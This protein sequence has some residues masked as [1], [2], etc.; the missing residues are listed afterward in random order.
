MKKITKK[1]IGLLV[2]IVLCISL[3][4]ISTLA[5]SGDNGTDIN[6][7][8]IKKVSEP[9][10]K[11][12]YNYC[13]T[14]A[15]ENM[16][17]SEVSAIRSSHSYYDVG[18]LDGEQI[19]IA[20]NKYPDRVSARSDP[21]HFQILVDNTEDVTGQAAYDQQNGIVTLPNVYAGHEIAVIW[22]CPSDEITELSMRVTQDIN[23]K[24]EHTVTTPDFVCSSDTDQIC[25]PLTGVSGV[26][27]AQNGVDIPEKDYAIENGMLMINTSVLGGDISINAAG[28]FPATRGTDKSTITST[29]DEKQIY[30]GY[31]TKYYWADGNQAFCID[32]TVSG[33]ANGVYAISRYLDRNG[34]DSDKLLIKCAYYLFGGPGYDS[35]KHGLFGDDADS[36][37]AYA[38]SHVAASY[39]YC[40]ENAFKGLG[41]AFINHAKNMVAAIDSQSM[42]P[43]GFDAFLYNEGGYSGQPMLSWDYTPV[44]NIFL[45][46]TSSKPEMTQGNNCYSLAGAVYGVYDENDKKVGTVTTDADGKGRMDG[47]NAGSYYLVEEVAPKGF[48]LDKTRIPCA[49]VGGET[50]TIVVLDKPQNDPVGILLRKLDVN[51]NIAAAQGGA[52]LANAEFTVKYYKGYYDKSNDLNGLKPERTWVFKTN[53]NGYTDISPNYLIAG[54]PL[55]YHS[56]GDPTLPLG[57]ITIQETKSPVGYL[58]NNELFIRQITPEGIVESVTTYNEPIIKESVIRGDVRVE[59]WDNETNT[60]KPQGDATLTNTKLEIVNRSTASVIVNGRSY[61]PGTVVF[62]MTTDANGIAGTQG[63]LLPFGRYELRESKPPE[64]YQENGVLSRL[65]DIKENGAIINL[66]TS[67]TA[68]KNDVIRGGVYIEKWDNEIDENRP[69]G[70][71]TLE[72]AVFE[73]VNRSKSSVLVNGASYIPGKVVHT[74][75]TDVDGK[76]KTPNSLLPYGTYEVREISPP[77]EGYL[78][79]GVLSRTFQIRENG[80]MVNLNTSGTAIKNDPIRGDIK[81]VKIADGDAGRMAN[82]PF[83]ITSATTGESHIIITD[84][85][86][87]FDTSSSWNPHSQN[88]NR[89]TTDKDGIW[90]GDQD[91][92]NDDEGALP[93]DDYIIDELLCEANKDK[94]LLTFEIAVYR[95]STVLDLGTLTD[96]YIMVPEIFTT[97]L[98]SET[99]INDAHTSKTTTLRDTVYHSGLS[100][101]KLYTIQGILMDKKTGEPLLLDGKQIVSEYTFRAL[102]PSGNITVE[103]T[104]DST[105][106][107][108]KSIVVFESLMR[109]GKIVAEHKEIEDE[110]QTIR[111]V[112]PAIK[113]NATGQAGE[114]DLDIGSETTIIDTV[115]YKG[116]IPGETYMLK[117]TVMDKKT[118]EPVLI[119]GQQITSETSF[120]SE[121]EQGEVEVAFVFNNVSLKGKEVVIFEQLYFKGREVASHTD[122]NDKKQT[123]KCKEP[124]ISTNAMGMTGQK[125][126]LTAK[127][128]TLVDSV[129]FMDLVPGIEYHLK[130]KL[131]DKE[132]GQPIMVN[133]EEVIAET[134]FTPMF[135]TGKVQVIFTFNALGLKG[136]EIVIFESLLLGKTEV[137]RHADIDDKDQ[138]VKFVTAAM[139]PPKTGDDKNVIPLIII[140]AAAG[141]SMLAICIRKKKAEK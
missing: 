120:A 58:I 61:A 7:D 68:I 80:K 66:N 76:A 75:K 139:T 127:E 70:S 40:G 115:S 130:G 137:A 63:N 90:F 51:S 55:Y 81:G 54:D 136:K 107:D 43:S 28:A 117:G 2:A 44:G 41:S 112:E 46:K 118:G 4:P 33:T 84:R 140:A 100:V 57:T 5:G 116:L 62:A 129:L 53:V 49:V 15:T 85:N 18:V 126:L 88:T 31:Y 87:Q 133:D 14:G 73:I 92:L 91:T 22:N 16:G 128:V 82:I 27:V 109:D 12:T 119:A 48:A 35:V 67:G 50:I 71:G 30:Y 122:I 110:G 86:G 72:G 83:K 98:D 106:L 11:V 21:P 34:S 105:S 59:K 1:L 99:M 23:R 10:V 79:I 8:Q 37:T 77:L 13:D 113:T 93:Y 56:T 24:D 125:E 69:Q 38:L 78:A 135:K 17:D 141:V 3:A 95:D 42:P 45:E 121:K 39:V 26:S 96:D 9:L 36:D 123:V 60:N 6:I 47:L 97:A 32:P 124:R 52:S 64:G 111:F 25:I 132:T 114:K 74:I 134:R 108:G 29:R 94:E 138:T 65:F 101:G 103:Y 131:M 20:A 19:H 104:F 89:G 102:R